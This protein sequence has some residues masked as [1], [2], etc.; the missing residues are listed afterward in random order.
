[1][2]LEGKRKRESPKIV[3]IDWFCWKNSLIQ[4]LRGQRPLHFKVH[5]TTADNC[6]GFNPGTMYSRAD[7]LIVVLK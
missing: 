4:L 7:M 3:V 1:M 5:K 2:G 6:C